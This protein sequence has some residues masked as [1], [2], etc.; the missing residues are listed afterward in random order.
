MAQKLYFETEDKALVAAFVL[1]FVSQTLVALTKQ[2]REK[3]P[4][5]PII[6]AGGV[7]SNKMLK[8]KL[9]AFDKTY[10]AEP[11]FSADNAA[12]IALLAKKNY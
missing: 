8:E 4:E 12:G 3:H 6:Y 11:A 9:S 2:V 7:M 1:D 10:F 5:V